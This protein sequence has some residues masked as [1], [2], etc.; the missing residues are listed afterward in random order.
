L[1][2]KNTIVVNLRMLGKKFGEYRC[3]LG[4]DFVIFSP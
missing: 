2:V 3:P 1:L 4:A